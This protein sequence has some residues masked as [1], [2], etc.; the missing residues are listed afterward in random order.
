MQGACGAPAVA[1]GVPQGERPAVAYRVGDGEQDPGVRGG[2]PTGLL[3]EGE[4]VQERAES[5]R[6]V[7]GQH[8]PDL[9]RCRLA[10]RVPGRAEPRPAAGDQAEQH[11]QRLVVAEHERRQAVPGGEPVAA[12]AA[13]HRLHGHVEVEQMVHIAPHGPAVDAE[14]V[15]EF[16]HRAGAARL[17]QL[18]EGQHAAGGSG[19][20]PSLG[21]I[22]DRFCPLFLLLCAAQ[23]LQQPRRAP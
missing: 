19:H 23:R 5:V 18:Q 17:Q 6:E 9:G 8:P 11:R 4:R 1:V 20:V 10:R 13:A 15:G 16:G 22:A 3:R 7:R 12:V 21:R 2:G 14:A